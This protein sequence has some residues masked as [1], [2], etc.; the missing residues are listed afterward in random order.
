MKKLAIILLVLLA[1]LMVAYYTYLKPNFLVVNGYAAKNLCSCVFVAGIDEKT[2]RQIDLG[3]SF[4]GLTNTH[5]NYATQ[6]TTSNV[7]GLV[8]RKAVYRDGLGCVLVNELPEEELREKTF[9]ASIKP[10]DSLKNWFED[11]TTAVITGEQSRQIEKIITSAFENDPENTI[12]TR[13]VVVLY[14]GKLIGEQYA[15]EVSKDTRLL[16]W[17]MTKSLT[18]TMA[19]L[20]I[21]DSLFRLNTQVP[22]PEWKNTDKES[23]TYQDLLQMS[24]GLRFEEDYGS[25]SDAN[26]MLWI[27]DS[28]GEATISKPLEAAPGEKW[29]YSSGTTNLL[30][31]LMRSYFSNDDQY[32]DYLNQELFNRIG[33]YS[34]LIEPDASGHFV[35]S[36]FGW[37]T[38]RDWARVGQLYLNDGRWGGEQILPASWVSFVQ[39]AP[40]D[41]EALGRYGGQFWL[42][43]SHPELPKDTYYMGGFHG[44]RVFII[45]SEQLVVVRLGVTYN[46]DFDFDDFVNRLI[47]VLEE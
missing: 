17:S 6:S 7:W 20:M 37:A 31:R 19:G 3:F 28:M 23:I 8:P 40:L 12:N 14:K 43:A 11:D 41:S 21:R 36:S 5:V 27:S 24:S 30:M 16:G 33:A 42:Q 4:I 44:Q 15:P 13:G 2:V 34:F 9:E 25:Y 46:G 26:I 10:M 1:T 47:D 32:L 22:I 18:S 35:G 39:Q 29:Y 45:P 38:A